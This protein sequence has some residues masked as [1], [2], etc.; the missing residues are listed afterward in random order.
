MTAQGHMRGHLLKC[1]QRVL[2]LYM[3]TPALPRVDRGQ[4]EPKS[5]CCEA[6]EMRWSRVCSLHWSPHKEFLESTKQPL[7]KCFCHYSSLQ[8]TLE[9]AQL[10]L[11]VTLSIAVFQ[12]QRKLAGCNHTEAQLLL[13]HGLVLAL[14]A[15]REKTAEKR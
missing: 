6:S 11:P 10:K 12:E 2:A 4:P 7:K 15:G 5:V 14:A 9:V 8:Q 3:S 13:H 1:W